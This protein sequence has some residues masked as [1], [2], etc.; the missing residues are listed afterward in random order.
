MPRL[1]NTAPLMG[2]RLSA[3]WLIGEMQMCA[4]AA[5]LEVKLYRRRRR[6]EEGRAVL[7]STDGFHSVFI[8]SDLDIA[9]RH[10]TFPSGACRGAR[11]YGAHL[12]LNAAIRL[13]SRA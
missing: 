11:I 3:P 8:R 2:E 12:Q 13:L 1:G 4:Y 7:G 6:E 10:P 5:H 9:P